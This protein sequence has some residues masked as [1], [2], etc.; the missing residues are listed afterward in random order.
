MISR[1]SILTAMGVAVCVQKA[2]GQAAGDA[3]RVVIDTDTANGIDD[4][5]ALAYALRAPDVMS[6][7][8]I[9]AAPFVTDSAPDPSQGTQASYEEIQRVLDR[10]GRSDFQ[11]VYKGATSFMKAPW[12]PVDSPAARDLI[13]RATPGPTRLYVIAIGAATNVSSAFLL[14]PSIRD[15]I[16]VIWLGG[17]PYDGPNAREYNLEQDVHASRVLFESS[18]R[19]VNVPVNGVSDKLTVTADELQAALQGKSRIGDYLCEI[20]ADRS[21]Q[22]NPSAVLTSKTI[23]DLAAVAYLINP[24]WVKSTMVSSPILNSDFTWSQDTNRHGVRVATE[25]N[26]DAIFAD[27]FERIAG[28]D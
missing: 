21:R 5:F 6:V 12:Q 18:V 25:V 26:R 9:Y 1:R 14:D 23:W 19:L 8:A 22:H 2:G 11:Q 10:L 17:Q 28:A 16:N 13:E 24:G 7:E 4:Q 3:V 15:R 27:F 20:F